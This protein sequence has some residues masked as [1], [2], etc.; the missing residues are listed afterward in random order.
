MVAEIAFHEIIIK[1]LNAFMANKMNVSPEEIDAF[2]EPYQ[3]QETMTK[4]VQS[5]HRRTMKRI[6]ELEASSS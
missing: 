2:L 1:G 6:Q 4:Y 5:V 3:N